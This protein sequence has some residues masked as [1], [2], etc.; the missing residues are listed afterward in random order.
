MPSEDR[1]GDSVG[2]GLEGGKVGGVETSQEA[3]LADQ[4]K[5]NEGV[6]ATESRGVDSGVIVSEK[7]QAKFQILEA[8][9]FPQWLVSSFLR[10]SFVLE[11]QCLSLL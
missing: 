1:I 11:V 6:T 4:M 2:G 9:D 8:H 10:F 5:G 3:I 7:D